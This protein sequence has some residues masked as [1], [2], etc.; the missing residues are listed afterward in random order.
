MSVSDANV[1]DTIPCK[2]T[3]VWAERERKDSLL[4]IDLLYRLKRLYR[5]AWRIVLIVDSCIAHTKKVPSPKALRW[6][7][8][9][10]GVGRR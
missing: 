2:H 1:P 9:E 6:R 3:V 10:V 5:R 8:V 7:H 4:F